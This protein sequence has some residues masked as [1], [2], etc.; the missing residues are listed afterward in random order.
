M[1]YKEKICFAVS[2]EEVEE[3][4]I[5]KLAEKKIP[6]EYTRPALYRNAVLERVAVDMPSILILSEDLPDGGSNLPFDALIKTIKVKYKSCRII[7]LAG[8]H[9]PGDEFLNRLVS[10]GIYDIVVGS[11]V[12]LTEVLDCIITPKEYDYAEKFQGLET[13]MDKDIKT[14]EAVEEASEQSKRSFFS[15]KTENSY[16]EKNVSSPAIPSPS[17]KPAPK[18]TPVAVSTNII[19]NP[20]QTPDQAQNKDRDVSLKYKAE[21]GGANYGTSILTSNDNPFGTSV[22]TTDDSANKPGIIFEKV[23]QKGIIFEKVPATSVSYPAEKINTNT[24]NN[25]VSSTEFEKQNSV[26]AEIVSEG[27]FVTE[28]TPS[29]HLVSDENILT[30]KENNFITQPPSVG[31][32]PKIT[33][34]VSAREGVGCTT[35]L[36]NTAHALASKGKKVLVIDAVYSEKTIFEKLI[37]KH[38]PN[39]FNNDGT[40]LPLGFGSSY[41]KA[42]M[43]NKGN[44]VGGIQYLELIPGKIPDN[45]NLI[46][47]IRS[48]SGYDD[49]FI[50]MSL[51]FYDELVVGIINLADMVVAVTLQERYELIILRNYLNTYQHSANIYNGKLLIVVNRANPKLSPT[52]KDVAN[53]IPAKEVMIIPSD[54]D[55]FIRAGVAKAPDTCIYKG[56]RKIKELYSLLASKV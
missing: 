7:V 41:Y 5:E 8:D 54:P 52:I 42:V 30:N 49:I 10:R 46:S 53:Y 3:W 6:A 31:F 36:L 16:T 22:L 26:Q 37:Y 38:V 29:D 23:I 27:T 56:K 12:Q 51:K 19:P 50:D 33:L 45:Y 25:S 44:I 40:P 17:P 21:D 55:G 1:K 47:T 35:T 48:F 4:L 24:A 14:V 39:G 11:R 20:V 13:G 9:T 28:K 43:D 34:F 18:A 15:K 2:D 32:L